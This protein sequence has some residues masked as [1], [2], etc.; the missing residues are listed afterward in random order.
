[1][2]SVLGTFCPPILQCAALIIPPIYIQ[3]LL[4]H[5]S[6]LYIAAVVVAV[7]AFDL[8]PD[9]V[10]LVTFCVTGKKM[11]SCFFIFE[12][13]LATEIKVQIFPSIA[14]LNLFCNNKW[15][16][17]SHLTCMFKFYYLQRVNVKQPAQQRFSQLRL[18]RTCE[19]Y[20]AISC[21]CTALSI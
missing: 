13:F 12:E 11:S 6:V 21:L 4:C 10:H 9:D 8:Q 2:N 16:T 20:Q 17:S 15:Y 14:F 19:C 5:Q 18:G 7:G 3:H 1:M